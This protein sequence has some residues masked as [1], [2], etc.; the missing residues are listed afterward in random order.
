M[1]KVV[2]TFG[3]YN[4]PTVGHAEL[5][6]YAVNLA[7]RTG[8]E[9]RIYT[10]QSHDSS[11]NPLAPRQKMAFL[12]Q[13]FPGVNFVNDPNMKTAFAICKKLAD[14][15]YEDVTFV[16]GD[17]RVREFSTAL[18]K[19]V[20]PRTAKGFDP[21][22]NYPFKK[23]Q[24]VSSGGRKEGISGTSL[25]AAV[26]KGDFTTFAKASAARDKKL[27]R[28]IYRATKSQLHERYLA[29][30]KGIS[31][32]DFHDKLLSFV[33]YTCNHL[34]IKEKPEIKYREDHG[35]GQPSFAAYAPGTKEVYIMTKNRHPMDVFRSV[36][37][38]L[39]HHKQNE[40]GRLNDVAKEGQTGS[41][42]ENEA[43]SEAGKIMRY[44]GKEN[45]FYFDMQY[46][47]EQ[48]AIV[49][50]GTPGSGKDKILKEAILP[51]GFTEISSEHINKMKL[52][53]NV[54]VTG[55]SNY[56]KIATIKEQL[57]LLGY[58]SIMV[59][60]NTSDEVSRQR[61]E[62]RASR[63]GRVISEV[64]RFAKWQ[65]AQYDL[66]RFDNLFERVI[67]VKNDLDLNQPQNVIHE[68]YERLIGSVSEEIEH[69]ALNEADRKFQNMLNEVGG[70][71]NFG[72]DNLR[73]VYQKMTPGQER[74]ITTPSGKKVKLTMKYKKQR[75]QKDPIKADRIGPELGLPKNPTMGAPFDDNASIGTPIGD[76]VGRWMVKEETKRR[77]REKYGALA[78]QKL[79]ETAARL[80]K[81]YTEALY[82]P[83]IAGQGMT[84]NSGNYDDIMPDPN[85]PFEKTSLFGKKRIKKTK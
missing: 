25:R 8:A 59:F 78:E 6:T 70:A 57:D 26:R 80:K 39:V 72:T 75:I 65:D 21:K 67:E 13:I 69:F 63:G 23:F 41:P 9:H 22:I 55:T 50:A 27:A 2:F 43:N 28:E 5:I 7:H 19:Y 58:N 44:F 68:T 48:K 32:K 62:A 46:I 14:E 54:V 82:D 12:R 52:E 4:P 38:E 37:H 29:E 40:D 10:S 18:G 66:D 84:P 36:A 53:G 24:V 85:V 34:G 76:P 74:H 1:K 17:D 11:K 20:K 77:F 45:P 79:R 49:V 60:V 42:I 73:I 15:G 47:G 56:D 3:R 30:Q 81:S 16:V 61:N 51:Y 64:V 31:R 83:T 35:E 33:D 71:G